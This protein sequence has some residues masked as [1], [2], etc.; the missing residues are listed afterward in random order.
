MINIDYT[1][2]SDDGEFRYEEDSGSG[3]VPRV[4]ELVTFDQDHSYQVVDVLW[5]LGQDAPHITVTACELDWHKHIDKITNQ[6][7][8]NNAGQ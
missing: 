7:Q 8:H 3:H 4:G 6:W 5:H 2:R 1:L